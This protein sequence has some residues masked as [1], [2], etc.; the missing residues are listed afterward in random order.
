MPIVQQIFLL[1]VG[2]IIGGVSVY[3]YLYPKLDKMAKWKD[4]VVRSL[5]ARDIP[6]GEFP[7]V[8]T[9]EEIKRLKA[10]YDW[11]YLAHKEEG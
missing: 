9:A 6:T 11:S 2:V 1:V 8:R 5:P 4:N 3:A 7:V 10:K